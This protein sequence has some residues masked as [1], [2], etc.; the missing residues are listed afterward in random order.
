[1]TSP[2]PGIYVKEAH[3]TLR[4]TDQPSITLDKNGRVHGT[5]DSDSSRGTGHI[6]GVAYNLNSEAS[7]VPAAMKSAYAR[8]HY[9]V[10]AGGWYK[11]GQMHRYMDTTGSRSSSN[12][13]IYYRNKGADVNVHYHIQALDTAGIERV[14]HEHSDRIENHLARVRRTNQSYVAVV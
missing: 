2:V 12:E 3:P 5:P 7:G 11:D 13:D 1:M 4:N 6:N 9:H 10:K 8:N 14:L